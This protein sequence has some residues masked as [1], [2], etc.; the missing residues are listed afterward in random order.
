MF[1]IN[2]IL[3]IVLLCMYISLKVCIYVFL[4]KYFGFELK[5]KRGILWFLIYFMEVN[6]V[7][8]FLKMY[9]LSGS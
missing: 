7:S 5:V 9:I 3:V 6:F 4:K 8:S 2:C 1:I